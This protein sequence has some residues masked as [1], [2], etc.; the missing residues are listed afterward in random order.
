MNTPEKSE[1]GNERIGKS[2]NPAVYNE[3]RKTTNRK[4]SKQER[5]IL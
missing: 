1:N 5:L 2:M 4:P 3:M